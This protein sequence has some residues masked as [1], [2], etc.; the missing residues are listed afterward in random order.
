MTATSG[1][2]DHEDWTETEESQGVA[3]SCTS[4]A[5]TQQ[6]PV[7]VEDSDTGTAKQTGDSE[8]GDCNTSWITP[9]S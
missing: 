4:A 9:S 1:D 2:T 3:Q 5:E 8:G 6:A 7:Q